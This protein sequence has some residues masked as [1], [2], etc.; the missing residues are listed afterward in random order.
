MTEG[1]C[2]Q[3]LLNVLIDKAIFKYPV[4]SLLYEEIIHARQIKGNGSLLE[5][6]NQ[7]PRDEKISIIRVGDKL[8]ENFSIP[9]EIKTRVLDNRKICIKPEFEILHLLFLKEDENYHNKYKSKEKASEYLQRI[10]SDYR[11][12]YNYNYKFFNNLSANELKSL[13]KVYSI[14]RHKVHDKDEETLD[15]LIK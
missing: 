11:K 9:K 4:E 15:C 10:C 5:K 1:T 14:K 3:A 12:T 13:I 8:S 6:I 7:L 2:E